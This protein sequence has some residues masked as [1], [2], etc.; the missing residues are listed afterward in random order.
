MF[1]NTFSPSTC[2]GQK[3][4]L[5]FS[6]S[7]PTGP[8]RSSSPD[9][10]I[11]PWMSSLS[12]SD[13]KPKGYQPNL[14]WSSKIPLTVIGLALLS[15][16]VS[17]MKREASQD[18]VCCQITEESEDKTPKT[19]IGRFILPRRVK[20]G[21]PNYH[22]GWQFAAYLSW[23]FFGVG[24]LTLIL[25]SCPPIA[26]WFSGS[27][28][29]GISFYD[30]TFMIGTASLMASFSLVGFA[31]AKGKYS[32]A[33]ADERTKPLGKITRGKA[34]L[35]MLGGSIGLVVFMIITL[36]TIYM[37]GH[38]SNK[39]LH[40]LVTFVASFMTA[41]LSLFSVFSFCYGWWRFIKPSAD[42]H[43]FDEEAYSE[44]LEK[45]KVDKWLNLSPEDDYILGEGMRRELEKA[46]AG[47]PVGSP[48][49][50]DAEAQDQPENASTS[51]QHKEMQL[52]LLN[53]W[54][55]DA[56]RRLVVLERLLKTINEEQN[57]R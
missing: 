26:Q 46:Q 54:R 17:G 29:L 16:C 11:R 56:R 52:W 55:H 53:R 8:K 39:S 22:K 57:L 47:Q 14:K 20:K 34:A 27:S 28:N 32:A 13:L 48:P 41:L 10:L 36:F 35:N 51:D 37:K 15:T 23:F 3:A 25:Y 40:V 19:L 44:L 6:D 33:Y 5:A 31:L 38:V 30:V 43:K 9:I 2:A 24:I 1:Q 21:N 49:A 4:N 7:L 42:P 50:H 18:F 45:W 12:E